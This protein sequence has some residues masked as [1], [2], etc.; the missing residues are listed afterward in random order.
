MKVPMSSILDV[1]VMLNLFWYDI[2]IYHGDY[3]RMKMVG[4]DFSLAIDKHS[5]PIWAPHIFASWTIDAKRIFV[6]F[7][8]NA[9]ED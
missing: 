2:P 9:D 8:G 3:L 5:A 1:D 7:Q 4:C 6:S